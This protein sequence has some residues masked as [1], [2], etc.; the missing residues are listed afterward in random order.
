M[1][2]ALIVGLDGVALLPAESKFLQSARPA[3]IILFARNC[4]SPDQIRHL[5]KAAHAAAG[6]P[7]LVAIDQ[8]GGRVQRL[9]PPHWRALPAAA[10]FLERACGDLE[11]ARRDAYTVARLTAHD[12]RQ[13]GI[14]MNCAPV[15]DL[16][17]AGAHDIVGDR[18]YGTTVAE[19]VALGRAVAQGL[20]DGGVVPVAKHI[21]GHGRAC[22]DSHLA[23]PVVDTA[24]DV[25]EA[26]DFAP[27][28]QL[29]DLPAAMTAHVVYSALDAQQAGSVSRRVT[30]TII[31]E[32]IGFDGLLMSDD[33]SM[34]ALSGSIGAR[35]AA[36]IAAGSD[37]ALHC[38]G[39]LEEMRDAAAHAG[40]LDG[41]ALERYQR[42]LALT[43]DMQHFDVDAACGCLARL[44]QNEAG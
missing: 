28:R 25:L 16:R 17:I 32:S 8:E 20:M 12:L 34:K 23:L 38:N 19:V 5:V 39:N 26:T 29:A 7:L 33:L 14:T 30:H 11:A 27:F 37:V 36:V 44:M 10:R 1:T 13:L 40:I 42:A 21:P 24:L 2:A 43:D 9:R 31:R 15:L 41:R 35:A 4:E 22:A 6:A 3:G 18:A